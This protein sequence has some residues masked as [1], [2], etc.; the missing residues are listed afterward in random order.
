MKKWPYLWYL[1]ESLSQDPEQHEYCTV[2]IAELI[3]KIFYWE[4]W[5]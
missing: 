3:N 2:D 1:K 5:V 4:M